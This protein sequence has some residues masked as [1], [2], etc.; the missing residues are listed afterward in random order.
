MAVRGAGGRKVSGGGK[1][2]VKEGD[3][4]GLMSVTEG[5]SNARV[6]RRT[7]V[8]LDTETHLAGGHV[9]T[10]GQTYGGLTGTAVNM[11]KR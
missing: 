4:G 3:M 8:G 9:G 2:R 6:R 7:D 10:R 1:S 11:V 5:P